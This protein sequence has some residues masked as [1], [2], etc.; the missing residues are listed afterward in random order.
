MMIDLICEQLHQ[1]EARTGLKPQGIYLGHATLR[2]LTNE[3][4]SCCF[5]PVPTTYRLARQQIRGVP[6]YE[7]DK[8][9]HCAI[10]SGDVST[11]G[12]CL[13]P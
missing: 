7:V 12:E 9:E 6:I 13:G 4:E 8:D 3:V 1:F 2:R 5:V 11:N 10:G